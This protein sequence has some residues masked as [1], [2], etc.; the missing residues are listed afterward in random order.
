M[1]VVVFTALLLNFCIVPLGR[2]TEW[3]RL[4]NRMDST[5]RY[6][7][8]TQ[9]AA[10]NPSVWE[11][12]HG[13]VVTAYVNICFSPEHTATGEMYRLRDDLDKKL[14]SGVDLDTLKWIWNRLGKT[15]P[16]G[17]RYIERHSPSFRDCFPPESS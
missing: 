7:R 15:G 16:H 17:K 9:P 14:A 2:Q 3:R 11:C 8:P 10:M 5:I 4:Q 13:W 1:L 12:A 6:L